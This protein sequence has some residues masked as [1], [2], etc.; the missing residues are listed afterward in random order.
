METRK[1]ARAIVY[2]PDQ[3]YLLLKAKKG[4]WQNPQGG[5]D[6]GETPIQA[7]RRETLEETGLEV[8]VLEGTEY[9][10]EYDTE[11]KGKQ[12]HTEITSYAARV[13][14]VKPVVLSEEDG[15]TDF[16]WVK[17]NEALSL[18]TKYPEQIQIF[19]EVVSRI[20]KR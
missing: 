17:Y 5:I 10:M 15:H 12:I 8:V 18:L 11:R 7:A 1:I 2:N 6:A 3:G 13:D 9:F 16:K 20:N 19:E 14:Y 4:Y